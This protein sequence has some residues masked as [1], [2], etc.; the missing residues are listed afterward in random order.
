MIETMVITTI[1]AVNKTMIKKDWPWLSI[2]LWCFAA[3]TVV[4]M[5]GSESNS[6][7]RVTGWGQL[8][9]G[10]FRVVWRYGEMNQVALFMVKSSIFAVH[11]LEITSHMAGFGLFRCPSPRFWRDFCRRR[12]LYPALPSLQRLV[13]DPLMV[14]SRHEMLQKLEVLQW[15]LFGLMLNY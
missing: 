6:R 5:F 10:H 15:W 11:C 8:R 2:Y 4:P 9:L 12:W 3:A 13:L 1:K 14:P 7:L